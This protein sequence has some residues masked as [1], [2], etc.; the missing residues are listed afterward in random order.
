MASRFRDAGDEASAGI[1]DV[2]LSEEVGHV[3]AGMRWFR[4]L[5]AKSGQD[6]VESFHTLVRT[7]FRGGLKPPFNEAAREQAGLSPAFYHQG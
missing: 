7:R 2:I 6:P 3:A 1:L 4:A 5:C